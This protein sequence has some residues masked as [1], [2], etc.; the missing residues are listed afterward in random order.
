MKLSLNLLAVGAAAVLALPALADTYMLSNGGSAFA[1]PGNYG[2]VSLV[3][4]GSAVDFTV[5]MASALQFF[6]N[7]GNPNQS[8]DA[9]AFNATGVALN[10]I[11]NIVMNG[12]GV[13]TYASTT[14]GANSPFGNFNFGIFANG[15]CQGNCP[16]SGALTFT[17]LNST[18]SDFLRLSTGGT[19]NA[20]FAADILSNGA[21]GAVGVTSLVPEPE[22]YALM[23]AG[24]GVVGAIV[25]RRRRV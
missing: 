21:T 14:P 17:V 20:Y 25:C 8:H 13:T 7:T 24:L 23:L 4:N 3:Q 9:F 2:T 16:A 19:P 6:V 12:A 10:E 1:T 15:Y 18:V 5:T 11:T 22:S